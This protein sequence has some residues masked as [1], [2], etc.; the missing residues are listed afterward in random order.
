[1]NKILI[2][3]FFTF[4][5]SFSNIFFYPSEAKADAASDL[6]NCNKAVDRLNTLGFSYPRYPQNQQTLNWG[7]TLTCGEV[8]GTT[9]M[10][11]ILINP[12]RLEVHNYLTGRGYCINWNTN[13][14][15]KFQNRNE[16]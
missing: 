9:D 2:L 14:I 16:C 1:M 11:T 15:K 8:E 4:I 13:R 6:G 12:L 5:I 7:G 10:I 3:F